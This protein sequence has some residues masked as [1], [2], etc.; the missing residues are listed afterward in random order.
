MKRHIFLYL[1]FMASTFSVFSQTSPTGNNVPNT[2]PT[3]TLARSAWYRG[4]NTFPGAGT[5]NTPNGANIFGTGWNSPI[6]TETDNLIRTRLN[7]TLNTG[8]NGVLGHD[9]SGYF[10]IAPNGYFATNTPW[11]MLHLDGDNNTP[12][13]GNGW[14]KW[15][16]T[17]VFMKEHV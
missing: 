13:S 1:A 6:Y 10:G 17:G 14:R 12:Y 15:M 7:G 11:S 8:L 3:A 16:K 5:S 4:G 9:V 2:Q